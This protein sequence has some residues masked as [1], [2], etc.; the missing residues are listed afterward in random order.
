MAL[1]ADSTIL[2]ATFGAAHTVDGVALTQVI[3]DED[4]S[5]PRTGPEFAGLQQRRRL[6]YLDASLITR[7]AIGA[8]IAIDGANATVLDLVDEDGLLILTLALNDDAEAVQTCTVIHYT[9]GDGWAARTEASRETAIP[10][11]WMP[12]EKVVPTRLGRETVSDA[13]F[14]FGA[15]SGLTGIEVGDVIILTGGATTWEV[16]D[17]RQ[18]VDLSGYR[19]QWAGAVI[20]RA[21]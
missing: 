6:L 1:T 14:S 11:R 20:E 16:I 3:I 9:T 15:D 10:I 8:I 4:E 13:Q 17:V 19:Q 2:L 7:P 12:G 5:L 21:A 18:H